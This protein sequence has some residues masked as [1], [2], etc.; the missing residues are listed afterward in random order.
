MQ[1]YYDRE[2][3]VDYAKEWALRK[4]PR[5][6]ALA[7]SGGADFSSECIYSGCGVM[8]GFDKRGWYFNGGNDVGSA[9]QKNENLYRFLI[10]NKKSG[11]FA[12]ET[13]ISEIMPGD[14]VLM[15]RGNK[16]VQSAVVADISGKRV[17]VCAHDMHSFM[18]PLESYKYSAIKF[19][20]IIGARS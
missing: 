2:A 9:W 12:R 13:G 7:A 8:N 19:L 18:R 4:N 6:E 20:H 3:S 1:I 5:Y 15:Y 16:I 14:I 10:K 17:R 11:P